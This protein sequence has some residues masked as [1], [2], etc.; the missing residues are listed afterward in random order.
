MSPMHSSLAHWSGGWNWKVGFEM[1][2]RG[3]HEA[4]IYEDIY[5]KMILIVNNSDD[6]RTNRAAAAGIG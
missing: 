4:W 3:A 1:R 2:V 6:F 5:A